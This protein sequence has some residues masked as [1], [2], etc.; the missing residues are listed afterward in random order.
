MSALEKKYYYPASAK[1]VSNNK[2]LYGENPINKRTNYNI[3]N[4]GFHRH[5][6]FGFKK[7]I[8]PNSLVSID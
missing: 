5:L 8:S 1:K 4:R 7:N 3:D 6:S 2:N